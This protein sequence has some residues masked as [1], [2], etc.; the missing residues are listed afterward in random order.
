MSLYGDTSYQ[1]DCFCFLGLAWEPFT[2]SVQRQEGGALKN[3]VQHFSGE[4]VAWEKTTS[5]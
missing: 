4:N 3:Q 5:S 1:R 2:V